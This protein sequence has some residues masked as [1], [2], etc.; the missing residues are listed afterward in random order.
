MR[1]R[2]LWLTA[3]LS[4]AVAAPM[5]GRADSPAGLKVFPP[6]IELR[7]QDD[8]QGVVIQA[9]DGEG[10]TRDVTAAA[11]RRLANAAV[12]DLVGQTLT[13][14]QDGQTQLVVEHGGVKTE[15]AVV[16]QGASQTRPVSFRRDVEPVF[17][18]HGCNS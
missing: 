14:R 4:V 17:M 1:I 18:K 12:A 11:K 5:S 9:V 8:R 6:A 16:V 3:A 10:V 2:T 13:P 15:V 7:G